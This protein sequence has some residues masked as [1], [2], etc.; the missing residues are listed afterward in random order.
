[1]GRY[2]ALLRGINVGG[3]NKVPMPEL[4]ALFEQRGFTAVATYINSGNVLFDSDAIDTAAV[5]TT[6]EVLLRDAFD[7]EVPVMVIAADA[8]AEAVAHAPDWWNRGGD[9]ISDTFFVLPPLT[10]QDVAAQVGEARAPY[11]QIAFYGQ[12]VFWSAPRK[13]YSRTRWSKVVQFPVYRSLTI[14]NA[15]TTVKLARLAQGDR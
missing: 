6:C 2:I 7:F 4:K 9:E 14:R 15:N 12:V 13:T 10:P 8:L 1:M 3:K 11:E 5:R